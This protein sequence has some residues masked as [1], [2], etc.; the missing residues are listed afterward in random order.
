[1]L[2]TT[3]ASRT[4]KA[5]TTQVGR[6]LLAGKRGAFAQAGFSMVEILVTICV[7]ATGLLGLAALQMQINNA[8]FEAYQR[9]QA[10]ILMQDM[11]DKI[12]S[13]RQVASCMGF[14]TTASS[15][16]PFVGAAGTGALAAAVPCL[17]TGTPSIDARADSVIREWADAIS[18][19][20]ELKG[21]ATVGAMVGARGCVYHTAQV[22]LIPPYLTVVISW[23]GQNETFAPRDGTTLSPATNERLC[24]KDLYGSETRHRQ[25]WTTVSIGDLKT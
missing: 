25:I 6:T 21:S 17:V 5:P 20:N 4:R 1:M 2:T 8:E 24:A 19:V 7:V 23:Q 14:T 11:V 3:M 10:L 12:N 22:G 16:T 18:G 9:T 15:G 13:N